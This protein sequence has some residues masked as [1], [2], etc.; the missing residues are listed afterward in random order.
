MYERDTKG[1]S[2]A[3]RV[4]SLVNI[5]ASFP[6]PLAIVAVPRNFV[7]VLA[8]A[9]NVEIIVAIQI[10]RKHREGTV[11]SGGDDG[12]G[13]N[14]AVAVVPV[15]RNLVVLVAG[16]ENVDMAVVVQIGCMHRACKESVSRDGV[17]F[18]RL[19]NNLWARFDHRGHNRL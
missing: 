3:S 14:G 13:E 2:T 18:M 8:G 6:V 15:P 16:T 1:A 11:S 12:L 17:L 10:G 5:E 4:Q 19:E 9:E 7:T